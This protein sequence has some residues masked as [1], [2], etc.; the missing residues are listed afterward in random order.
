MTVLLDLRYAW[1]GLLRAKSFAM[2]ALITLAL[3]VGVNTAVFSV[4][5]AVLLK[6]LPYAN[7]EQL[8]FIWASFRTAGT[9]RGVVSGPILGEIER[10]NRSLAGV[11][12]IW[13]GADTFT[14]GD[15]EQVRVGQVTRNFFDVLGVRAAQ[16]RTFV[17][18][19][20]AGGR[21]AIVLADSFFRRRFAGNAAL[22]GTGLAM[23]SA[24]ATLVG[25]LPADFLLHFAPD[26]NVPADVQAFEPFLYDIYAGRRTLYYIRTIGRLKPG[27]SLADAQSD[28]D[29][30]AAE[31]RGAYTEFAGINLH[32]Q[33]AGMHADA[34]RDLQP[35]LAVLFAGAAFVLLICCVNV[36][37][38]LLARAG[39]RRKEIA[40]R[41]ALGASRGRIVR[42]L[43]A[44][45]ALLCLLGGA[46]GIA[47]G[48]AGF[49]ALLSIRPERFAHIGETGLS[50]PALAFA[51]ATSLAAALLFGLAPAA[52][53][54]RF[55]LIETLRASGRSWRGR[56]HRRTGGA[57]VAGE[58][59]LAFV[60]V[61]GATL[62]ART[63]SKTREV[64]PGFEAQHLL[65]FQINFGETLSPSIPPGMIGDWETQMRA[66]PGVE[67]VGGTSHLPLDD[68]PNWYGPFR[69]EG[70]T[71]SQSAAMV[72]D[73]RAITPG[74]LAAM[75]VRL[76][77][78][79][80]FDQRDR[81][82]G[83]QVVIVDELLARSTWPGQPAVGKRLEASHAVKYG[84]ALVPSEVVGVVEHVRN[85]SLTREVRGEIYVPF[86]QSP[87]SP[88][89]FAVRSR[90]DAL[91]LVP[92]IREMLRRRAPGLAMAKVRP[93]T[94]YVAREIAPV[95]FTAVLAA[96][97]GV[98]ALLLA[99][100]GIYGVL[101]YQVS[102][103]LPE[104]GIRM[105]MGARGRD[106]IHLV[107]REGMRLTFAGIVMGAVAALAAARWLAALVYGI[108]AR[109]PLSYALALVLLPAAALF[110]CWRPARRAASAD[111]S[112]IIREE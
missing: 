64:R 29:R 15:P 4:F 1:R 18:E 74:Y 38:L 62:A 72:A 110:G 46:A 88:L 54:M 61:T 14:G 60:L 82:G 107:L 68:F 98:L 105:A 47:A 75:G 97:F 58:I 44:E 59:A 101:N 25:V 2:V 32:F 10:R 12:G 50:W 99:A 92:A 104:M 55:D 6:P 57:L 37:S 17:K 41:L 51:A 7:P 73:N 96:V 39:D 69:P 91:A 28:L 20:E 27:A 8:V 49:R 80:Y 26:T 103:S 86:A 24:D 93:M 45:S 95:S 33:V 3:G 65:T 48:W 42:Q 109:D 102:R 112:Q 31:I 30:V 94:A 19:E 23:R 89:T 9:G 67:R 56:R 111:P 16:G 83:R 43:L 35:A 34:V 11:A 13:V 21:P 66:L 52:E 22:L 108:S 77:E 79:R 70:V 76:L 40:V 85:H 53:S 84:L 5:H 90:G 81:A 100:T 87:R 36:T 71:G 78:G 63:L 106:V